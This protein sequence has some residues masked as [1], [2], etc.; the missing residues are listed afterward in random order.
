MDHE[1]YNQL[2]AR[3]LFKSA[4]GDS[5]A[6]QSNAPQPPAK[7]A[8]EKAAAAA[9]AAAEANV[10]APALSAAEEQLAGRILN[11]DNGPLWTREFSFAEPDCFQ[12]QQ[13]LDAIGSKHL[14]LYSLR[15]QRKSAYFPWLCAGCWPHA[16]DHERS[17]KRYQRRVRRAR[18][19]HRRRH[20]PRFRRVSRSD[21][22][23]LLTFWCFSL[24]ALSAR[25]AQH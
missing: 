18:L 11:D 4:D 12:L 22:L 8:A 25:F 16:A 6:A 19:A 9:Q 7:T 21:Y 24:C 20:E 13:A 14:V 10:N 1:Y 3:W 23:V 5:S 15:K 17:S 2:I